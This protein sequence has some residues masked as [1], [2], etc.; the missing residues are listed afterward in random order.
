M[1]RLQTADLTKQTKLVVLY[2]GQDGAQLVIM[3]QMILIVLTPDPH[4][5]EFHNMLRDQRLNIEPK[6][7]KSNLTH[8]VQLIPSGNKVLFKQ[9]QETF[10]N[11]LIMLI[12]QHLSK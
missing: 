9:P 2:Q 1:M 8:S 5:E 11:K 4:C 10:A 3:Q 7:I 6:N 12:R